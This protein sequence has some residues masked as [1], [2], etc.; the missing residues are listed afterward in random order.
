MDHLSDAPKV[1]LIVW[2]S[3]VATSIPAVLGLRNQVKSARSTA[4]NLK[5]GSTGPWVWTTLAL[6]GQVCG[7]ILPQLVY[8]TTIAWNK[9]H[10]PGWMAK[11]AL[12]PPPDVFG[13]DGVTVGRA[14]GLLAR[15]AGG[16]LAQMAMKALGDQYHA[17]GVSDLS[18]LGP[19]HTDWRLK[20]SLGY[21]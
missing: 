16:I 17:I 18:S 13:F 4:G 7:F 8:V 14:V 2:G 21:R 15:H 5:P 6:S 10:Q 12:P 19:P 20:L 1:E 3:I 11:H 9:F